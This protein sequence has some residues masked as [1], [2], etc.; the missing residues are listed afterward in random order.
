MTEEEYG[1][2]LNENPLLQKLIRDK[3]MLTPDEFQNVEMDFKARFP[4]R[5][6]NTFLAENNLL[7]EDICTDV[8][9]FDTK[10]KRTYNANVLNPIRRTKIDTFNIHEF[11]TESIQNNQL[12]YLNFD[13]SPD[14]DFEDDGHEELQG[15]SIAR[16][17][18][19]DIAKIV[20]F[21]N[22]QKKDIPYTILEVVQQRYIN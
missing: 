17:S 11:L 19:K 14:L 15:S 22:Q 13:P 1:I 16:E 5:D 8:P 18:L 2:F 20:L 6:F 21:V 10:L 12:C 9:I 7:S 3:N 4:Y